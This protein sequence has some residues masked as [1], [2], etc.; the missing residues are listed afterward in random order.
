[1]NLS[2]QSVKYATKMAWS[3]RSER[4]KGSTE[5]STPTVFTTDASSEATVVLLTCYE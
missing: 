4:Q 5:E 3:S 1:M 2:H